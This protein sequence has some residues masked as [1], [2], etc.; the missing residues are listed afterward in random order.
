MMKM[1]RRLFIGDDEDVVT[2]VDRR[3]WMYR[4]NDSHGRHSR[5]YVSSLDGFL[6]FAYANE[7][8]VERKTTR[9]GI[10]FRI[11]CPCSKCKNTHHKERDGVKLD[12]MKYG[13]M[14]DYTKWWADGE[15]YYHAYQDVGQSSN[16]IV[17][18]NEGYVEMVNDY[19]VHEGITWEEQTPN[20][21]AQGFYDM[22]QAADEPLCDGS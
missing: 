5:D 9:D 12:L 19:M 4:K 15:T 17:N 14:P 11:R 6:D 7:G 20:P 1:Q 18:N 22:L 8:I 3:E 13:F 10:V 16:L 21:S 2:I